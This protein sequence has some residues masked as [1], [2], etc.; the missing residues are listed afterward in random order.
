V[1]PV[2][3]V[4]CVAAAAA[5][6]A[7]RQLGKNL[8]GVTCCK[9][10]RMIFQSEEHKRRQPWQLENLQLQQHT[11]ENCIPAATQAAQQQQQQQH[12]QLAAISCCRWHNWDA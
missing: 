8:N 5:V 3:C 4:A 2:A 6:A 11:L 10:G 1:L 9:A 12:R 7:G